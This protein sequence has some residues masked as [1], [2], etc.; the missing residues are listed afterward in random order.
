MAKKKTITADEQALAAHE[1]SKAQTEMLRH[2]A[3][4]TS[5]LKN[6][7]QWV[8]GITGR[9]TGFIKA[10]TALA[11]VMEQMGAKFSKS[12]E[13]SRMEAL[14]MSENFQKA[15]VPANVYESFAF[16]LQASR[17][18]L[19]K[20]SRAMQDLFGVTL[21]TGENFGKLQAGLFAATTGMKSNDKGMS[22][23]AKSV[24]ETSM[25]FN[26]GRE[27]LVAAMN[28]LSRDTLNLM[29]A[30]GNNNTLLQETAVGLQGLIPDQ[31][32][33]AQ[34]VG[35][36]QKQF[37][38]AGL[39]ESLAMGFP[40]DE[41]MK[42][43][44]NTTQVLE[45][46]LAQGSEASKLLSGQGRTLIFQQEAMK[47][48]FGDLASKQAV[49]NQILER[50]VSEGI[51]EASRLTNKELATRLGRLV[52]ERGKQEKKFTDTMAMLKREI[53]TPLINEMS[54]F[55]MEMK[56]V[57]KDKNFKELLKTILVGIGK[58]II[59]IGTGILKIVSMLAKFINDMGWR[60]DIEAGVDA[61]SD[62]TN[63]LKE[64]GKTGDAQ[65]TIM[66]DAKKKT[67]SDRLSEALRSTSRFQIK[68]LTLVN[69]N[70]ASVIQSVKDG[71]Q[72]AARRATRGPATGGVTTNNTFNAAQ[73][74]AASPPNTSVYIPLAPTSR[75]ISRRD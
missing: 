24:D 7:G 53:I 34:A 21:A 64:I 5:S 13:A 65:L 4:N 46:I 74:Q 55:F 27:E 43:Q 16:S 2:I 63:M 38:M 67:D 35:N 61:I 31:K 30:T 3:G 19:D 71:T 54:S 6:I 51:T 8:S 17:L 59:L 22:T 11:P 70:L 41:I 18:G 9:I 36:L 44:M 25:A 40:V 12:F 39:V 32:L 48:S 58:T 45:A 14:A 33:F 75:S 68:Q 28:Q 50:A 10:T 15:G 47:G 52:D 73:G 37:T 26:L 60:E 66:N 56:S 57:L 23:L 69:K 62:V 29:A 20:N 49:R 1:A 72:D 42:G